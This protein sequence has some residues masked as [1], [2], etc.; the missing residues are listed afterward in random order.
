MG[1]GEVNEVKG[2]AKPVAG[3]FSVKQSKAPL[4]SKD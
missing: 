1:M 2:K 3:M 4:G